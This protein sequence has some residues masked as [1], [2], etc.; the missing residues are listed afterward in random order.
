MQ[1]R[2]LGRTGLE[3]TV[4][5]FGALTI[6]GAFG[7]VDDAVSANALHAAIDAGINFI[8]TSDA[9]G[10]GHSEH[11]IGAF[12]KQ[13][14]DRDRIIVCTK[15]GNNMVTGE[16]NFTPDYIRGTEEVTMV[17]FETGVHYMEWTEAVIRSAQTGQAVYLPL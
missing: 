4:V 14:A 1:T 9:Y 11:L 3:V 17:P 12:L 7:A 16:Q 15:G 10:A 13:R 5:G 6:G 8:D 2:L